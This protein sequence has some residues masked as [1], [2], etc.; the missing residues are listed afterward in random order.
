MNGMLHEC[1]N[2]F[3]LISNYVFSRIIGVLVTTLTDVSH[4]TVTQAAV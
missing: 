1:T 4:V 2:W 3:M